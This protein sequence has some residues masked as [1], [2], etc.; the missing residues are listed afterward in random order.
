MKARLSRS[1]PLPYPALRRPRAAPLRSPVALVLGF[2]VLIATGTS[3]LLLPLSARA[4]HTDLLTALFTATSAVCVTGLTVVDTA[5]HWSPIGQAVILILMEVG[6][7]GFMIG[8]TALTLVLRRRLSLRQRVIMR[9]IG[10]SA[11]LGDGG[12]L[13]ARTILFTLGCEAVGTL[14][15]WTRFAPRYGLR[16]GLWLALFHAVSAFTNGSFDLFRGH[17]LAAFGADPVVLLTIAGLIIVG[18]LSFVVVQELYQTRRWRRLSLDSRVVLLATTVLLTGGAALIFLTERHNPASLAG[19]PLGAQ[20][21]DAFFEAVAARTCGFTTWDFARSDPRS[22]FILIGLMF[23][24]GAPGSMAGGVK[25]PTVG[26]ILA[27][28]WSTVRGRAEATLLKRRLLAMEQA[29]ALA[30]AVLS[31]GLIVAVTL[32][33][34]LSEGPRLPAP[35]LNLIF[36]VT[37]AF[38]TV[39]FSVGVT[40]HL[41]A[42]GKLLLIATMFIGRLGPVTVVTALMGRPHGM[43]LR[44]PSES[45]RIG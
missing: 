27:G 12:E 24:G 16:D 5:T 18:G 39:G 42:L 28:V 21:L 38:G 40:A 36:E 33:I 15:L 41:S 23:I 17:S 4:G 31:V 29:Q 45:V 19:R 11:H 7:L 30:V 10:S 26:V 35:L 13:I 34:S 8:A 43:P 25:L 20:A 9:E 44:P 22:L 6:G 37:S 32:V 3:L 14:L 1:R 2:A